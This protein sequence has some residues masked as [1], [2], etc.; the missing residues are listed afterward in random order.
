MRLKQSI[1]FDKEVLSSTKSQKDKKRQK[2][3]T[4]SPK[5]LCEINIL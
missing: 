5:K 1:G 3:K 2:Y 4:K